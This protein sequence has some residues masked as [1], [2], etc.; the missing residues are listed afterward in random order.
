MAGIQGSRLNDASSALE[1]WRRILDVRENH[2]RAKRELRSRYL[3]EERFEDLEVFMRRFATVEELGRT[4]ESQI[5]GIEDE[6]KKLWL[7]FKVAEI[8]RDETNQPQKAVRH[9]E[10]VLGVD[11]RNLRAATELIELN[12]QLGDWRKL[13][14]VYEVAIAE[15]ADLASARLMLQ[16][17][18]VY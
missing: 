15:T 9:L 14:A 1:S 5:S 13:P 12:R 17:A 6:E 7:L 4:L 18:Q 11:P 3:A 8:W 16:A 2:D 10:T